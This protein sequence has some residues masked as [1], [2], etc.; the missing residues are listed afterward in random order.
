MLANPADFKISRG[1]MPTYVR[2][3]K[4]GDY[5][6]F[7]MLGTLVHK[8][9]DING[10]GS[11]FQI[12]PVDIMFARTVAFIGELLDKRE[13]FVTVWNKGITFGTK[14]SPAGNSRGCLGCDQHGESHP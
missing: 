12:V 4:D 9:I 10:K 3:R 6:Q 1:D 7:F 14:K 11:K 5:T 8:D 2:N 13:V